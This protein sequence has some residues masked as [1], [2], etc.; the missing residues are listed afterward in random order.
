MTIVREFKEAWRR[1][2]KRPGYALLSIVVLGVGLGVALFVFGAVNDI[3]LQPYPFPQANRLMSVGEPVR[4]N[5]GVGNIDSAQYLAL[6]GKLK[7][8]DAMGAATSGRVNLGDGKGGGATSYRS[9]RITASLGKM[10]GLQ[11][12]L[13]RG[14]TAADDVP[15]AR[16]VVLL[17]Q[18]LW[19]QAFHANPHIV[20]TS[21]K[22]NGQFATVVGVVP[23]AFKFPPEARVW[24]PLRL[25]PGQHEPVLA[26]ARLAP[27]MTLAQARAELD[28][29]AGPLQ[30]VLPPNQK[31]KPLAIEPMSYSF[32]PRD[33]RHWIWLMFAAAMLVLLLAC[34][35]VANLQ[36]VQTLKRQHELALRSALGSGRARLVTGAL[37]ESLMLSLAALVPAFAIMWGC[38]QWMNAAWVSIHPSSI[39]YEHGIDGWVVGFG[40]AV[41]L[42]TTALA[43]GIPAWRASRA[44]LNDALRD[45]N[46]GSS[47]G[48]ARVTKGLVIAEVAL[49]VVLLVGAGTFV[50]ALNRLLT[51]PAVGATHASQVLTAQLALPAAVYQTD[52]QRI[53]FFEDVVRRL[54][55]A[56][57]VMDATASYGAPSAIDSMGGHVGLPGHP[58]P[59]EGWPVDET[60]IVG[61]HFLATFGL[62]LTSGRF[63]DTRDRAD[64]QPVA[65]VDER[66]ARTLWPHGDAVQRQ[67]V[68]DPGKPDARTLTV[69][70][71]VQTLH[72][73][74]MMDEPQPGLLIP[75]AQS[76]GLAGLHAIGL[77]L[78]THGPAMAYVSELNA[79]VHA[80]DPTVA[81]Y[82]IYTQAQV[83][84]RNRAGLNVLTE[85]FGFLGFVALLLAAVG[86]YGVLA[87]S[88]AERTREIGIRRAIGAGNGAIARTVGKTLAWQ[89]GLGLVI[90]LVL[91]VPWSGLL[92]DPG[93]QTQAH[94]PGVFIPVVL[95]VI[96]ASAI[97]ALV[98]LLRALRVPPAEAL[99]YE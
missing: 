33:L 92:V 27:G 20:G 52:A 12:L 71:V 34:V 67:L 84:S 78:H 70:G 13:G 77:A 62:H 45:G 11:P 65:V 39:P 98:P 17:S 88:V 15:G 80:V 9:A 64:S 63:F 49:T 75:L 73:H 26:V 79:A 4:G 6:R 83:I 44:N 76:S 46:K 61:P 87:F 25:E 69:I 93:L 43:G 21:V 28:T 94:D 57:G 41:A 95:I 5:E 22:V 36:L 7:S 8:V 53:R 51:Q 19:Q 90:G 31:A 89:L 91:A 29:L 86:L 68:L 24:L 66:L 37:M 54:R 81:T 56:P 72:R 82:G 74:S 96:G 60:N 32:S 40:I 18:S 3:I 30:R 16:R 85:A 58:R 10:L 35:N 38:M 99:R 50:R 59:A 14:F 2:I 97:A 23:T 47:G 55:H 42:C 48:F 1:L